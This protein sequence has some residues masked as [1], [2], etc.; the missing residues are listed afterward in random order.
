MSKFICDVHTQAEKQLESAIKAANATLDS[1]N[2]CGLALIEA[3]KRV[4]HGRWLPWLRIKCPGIKA[5][6]VQNYI[7]IAHNWDAIQECR[8]SDPDAISSIREALRFL[9]DESSQ[10]RNGA[11]LN[12]KASTPALPEHTG[13]DLAGQTVST[14][15]PS[16]PAQTESHSCGRTESPETEQPTVADL[17]QMSVGNLKAKSDEL[18]RD[19]LPNVIKLAKAFNSALGDSPTDRIDIAELLRFQESISNIFL[20]AVAAL[21]KEVAACRG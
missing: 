3:K 11:D 20:D 17:D 6:Q 4:G 16:E 8:A 7:R 12:N 5:R 1:A 19:T 14:A 10:I 18:R 21:E 15:R 9:R 13:G 2:E